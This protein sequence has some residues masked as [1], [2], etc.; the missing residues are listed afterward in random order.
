[1][2][3]YQNM[4]DQKIITPSVLDDSQVFRESAVSHAPSRQQINQYHSGLASPASG[5]QV[6]TPPP[7]GTVRPSFRDQMNEDSVVIQDSNLDQ[8]KTEAS[9]M[10]LLGSAR[11]AGMNNEA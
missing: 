11:K 10:K 6:V 2:V 3:H 7:A 4:I 9:E 8:S 1:M 5:S